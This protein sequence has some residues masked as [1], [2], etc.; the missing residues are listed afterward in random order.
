MEPVYT[1]R[2]F[3]LL[4]RHFQRICGVNPLDHQHITVFF[5]L[6]FHVG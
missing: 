3:P 6:S 2:G 4:R 5:D 1:F